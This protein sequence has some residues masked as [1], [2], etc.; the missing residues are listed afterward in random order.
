MFGAPPEAGRG[1]GVV[2]RLHQS[3]DL[4]E[5]GAG[6]RAQG[7]EIHP[8]APQR[9]GD[10]PEEV[11]GVV[12]VV[13][14]ERVPLGQAVEEVAPVLP[15]LDE[16][17]AGP[18]AVEFLADREGVG[19]GAGVREGVGG[20]GG[21]VVRLVDQQQGAG[22]VVARL[23]GEEPTA[24]RGEDVVVVPDPHVVEGEGGAGDL[25]GADP[26]LAA[27]EAE[28]FKI[29]CVVLIPVEAREPGPFPADRG[30]REVGADIADA[31]EDGIDAVLGL[32]AHVPDGDGR[33]CPGPGV[34]GAH[35]GEGL[36]HL[37]LPGGLAGEVQQAVEVA[38]AELAERELEEY[39]GLAEPGRGLEADQRVAT[40]ERGELGNRALLT[41]S[42][43]G[44]GG[45][46]TERAQAGPR[47]EPQLEEVGH[48][49]QL[50][51]EARLVRGI[52]WDGLK[53]AI[54]CLDEHELGG[55][56][57]GGQR[58]LLGAR[59]GEAEPQ[60]GR[61]SGE[62]DEGGG[63]L[64]A[65]CGG[66]GGQRAQHRLNLAEGGACGAGEELVDAACER[67]PP[68]A[69][70]EGAG[71]RHLEAGSGPVHRACPGPE[72]LVPAGAELGAPE[73]TAALGASGRGSGRETGEFAHAESG[74]PLV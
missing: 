65:K 8:S 66:V 28:G 26:G 35:R 54:T 57:P 68:A 12:L 56:G 10:F 32:V 50:S 59:R 43:R 13:G 42:R 46:E 9:G 72:F 22:R 4:P 48:P 19:C 52:K 24:A 74:A 6:G 49:V 31:V 7:R 27:G 29:P 62:L 30:V 15:S 21:E 1:R 33:A 69:V 51:A 73:A 2:E 38:G 64:R 18:Y 11:A 14:G 63:V 67:E 3:G 53:E 61:V 17:R 60:E 25:V 40:E 41:R 70:D 23:F 71:E 45:L 5:G 58:R 55:G 20:A 47:A 37:Q 36:D 39:A 16:G 34:G 44:E